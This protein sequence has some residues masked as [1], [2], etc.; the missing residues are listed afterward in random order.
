GGAREAA[1]IG[2]QW[3]AGQGR[4]QL[5]GGERAHLQHL[6]GGEEAARQRGERGRQQRAA[7]ARGQ[8]GAQGGMRLAQAREVAQRAD[9][10]RLV[11]DQRHRPPAAV[12]ERRPQ[13]EQRVHRARGGGTAAGQ[14]AAQV[15][16]APEQRAE[17]LGGQ[18]LQRGRHE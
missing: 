17:G 18:H 7:A 16:G 14:R 1:G 8:R 4:Q 6:G 12:L 13:G 5:V 10:G 9:L 15:G 2:V 3:L 11:Q